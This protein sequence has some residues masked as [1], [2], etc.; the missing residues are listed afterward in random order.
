MEPVQVKPAMIHATGDF[1]LDIRYPKKVPMMIIKMKFTRKYHSF[2][3]EGK[4][5]FK[6]GMVPLNPLGV[7]D[8]MAAKAAVIATIIIRIRIEHMK[9]CT[10]SLQTSRN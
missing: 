3:Q 5:C 9:L 10:K 1:G 6:K 7:N 2:F 4:H 8:N